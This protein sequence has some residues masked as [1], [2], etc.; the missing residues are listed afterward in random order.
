MEQPQWCQWPLV[1]VIDEISSQRP[2]PSVKEGRDAIILELFYILEIQ[3]ALSPRVEN[4]GQMFLS[5][6]ARYYHQ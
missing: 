3:F 4:I 2:P 1:R 6:F 5:S